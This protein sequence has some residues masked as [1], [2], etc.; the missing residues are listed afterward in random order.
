MRWVYP[1]RGRTKAVL[2]SLWTW[3]QTTCL[4]IC[5]WTSPSLGLSTRE[6]N[7]KVATRAQTTPFEASA[8][9]WEIATNEQKN[10]HSLSPINL[11]LPGIFP[12]RRSWQLDQ[13]QTSVTWVFLIE[14]SDQVSTKA[15][16]VCLRKVMQMSQRIPQLLPKTKCWASTYRLPSRW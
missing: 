16:H 1:R 10:L 3:H 2:T 13:I 15:H 14:S 7:S 8:S 9:S 11:N 12:F 5:P 6:R 4:T